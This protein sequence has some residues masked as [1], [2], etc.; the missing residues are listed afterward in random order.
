VV[1]LKEENRR[2]RRQYKETLL[3][4]NLA[5]Q[6]QEAIINTI[7]SLEAVPPPKIFEP[8]I[9]EEEE[10]AL[11]L[12]SDLHIGEVVEA[13]ETYGIAEYNFEIF[14]ARLE[15]LKEKILHILLECL[16][17]YRFP[18]LVVAALG[19]MI[20]GM[21]HE[22]LVETSDLTTV[23]Q[24][25]EGAYELSLFLRDLAGCFQRIRFYGVSGNHGRLGKKIKYIRRWA[26]W[27]FIFYQTL[28]QLLKEQDNIEFILE[29]APFQIFEVSGSRF[30][31]EHGDNVRTWM[32]LPWYG[33][34]RERIR[35]KELVESVEGKSFDYLLVGHF[36]QC[37]QIDTPR[38]EMFLNGSFVGGSEFSIIKLGRSS[39]PTQLLLGIN[40]R[41]LVSF[42]FPLRLEEKRD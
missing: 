36:H 23:Q 5:S 32:T 12:L 33:L 7:G 19:D 10:T 9:E 26:N 42:R 17:G 6:I 41:G 37:G 4:A 15:I 40:K 31:M 24:A 21:I 35:K 3:K 39:L 18:E 34:E 11:L 14:K 30:L 1:A 38:G 20:S 16:Q 25:M 22:E 13:N 8:S 2:L 27:D 29:K 28:K